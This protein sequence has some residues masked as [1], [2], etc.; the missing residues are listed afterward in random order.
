MVQGRRA[1]RAGIDLNPTRRGGD[2]AANTADFQQNQFRSPTSDLRP[3]IS[4]FLTSD[5]LL[6][7]FQ[8]SF[9]LLKVPLLVGDQETEGIAEL[10]LHPIR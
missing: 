5:L 9:D 3:P 2:L 10:Q 6:P 8:D 4:H 1:E 7:T